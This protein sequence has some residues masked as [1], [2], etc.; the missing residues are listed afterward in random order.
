M[1]EVGRIGRRKAPD[2]SDGAKRERIGV[3]A[4]TVGRAVGARV[5]R[6]AAEYI[7]C[8]WVGGDN[9]GSCRSSMRGSIRGIYRFLEVR[10][11]GVEFKLTPKR[12]A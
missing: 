6:V 7:K 2:K 4:V 9:F 12:Q 11:V 1:Y 10:D 3:N 5:T 8:V